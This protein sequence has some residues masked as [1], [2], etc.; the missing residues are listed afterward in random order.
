MKYVGPFRS[1]EETRASVEQLQHD[2]LANGYCFWV[3]ERR[4]D[5]AM[6]GFCGLNPGPEDT[7]LEGRTEIGWR[8]AHHARGQG[9]GREAAQA[10]L[11]WG[12]AN[13]ADQTIWAITVPAHTRSWGL[14]ERLGM[15][16]QP[17]LD[18]DHPN[19]PVGNPLKRHITYCIG[20]P[21]V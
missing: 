13:L 3:I 1:I 10:S 6:I 19:V 14:M 5:K 21:P 2:Q 17:D 12:F 9:Y 7:P 8:L 15:V 4:A 11:N 16:R 18:F 20:K